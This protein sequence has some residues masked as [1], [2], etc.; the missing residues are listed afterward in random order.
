MLSRPTLLVCAAFALLVCT[1]AGLRAQ[2]GRARPTP[3]PDA[4]QIRVYTEEVRIPL[5]ARDEYGRF[6]PT[7]E[8]DDIVVLE[9]NVPQQV[10]SIK[11]IPASVL[12]VLG[13]GGELNPAQRTSSTRKAALGIVSTLRAGDAVAVMQF[14]RKIELLESW[15]TNFDVAK[16]ALQT[17]LHTGNGARTAEA[18]QQAARLFADQPMGN[19]H[20]VLVTDGVDTPGTATGKDE[21]LRILSASDAITL[22]GR[23]GFAEALKQLNAAQVTVHVISYTTIGRTTSKARAK[24]ATPLPPPGSV[25]SSGIPTVGID[26]TQPPTMNRGTGTGPPMGG[27]ITFDNKMNK[28]HKA[29]ERAMQRSEQRLKTLATE[30]GGRIWL[31]DSEE[32]FSAQGAEVAREIGTEYVV[33]YA[34][35][36]PLVGSDPYEYRRLNVLPRR[37]GLILRGRRGYVAAAAQHAPTARN[38]TQ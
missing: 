15:T 14:D 37:A 25:A 19:R 28:I 22:G 20:I 26:P 31:P 30:T 8:R 3:T 2:S 29:Y 11:R 38:E 6:D 4:D 27:G 17:K 23:T 16:H 33:T 21:L 10:R 18:L 34:P 9:D 35:K 5:F 32:D 1:P 36:R 13:T 24:T 7:L 12:L